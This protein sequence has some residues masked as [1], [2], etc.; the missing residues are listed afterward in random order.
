VDQTDAELVRRANAGSGRSFDVLVDRHYRRCLRYARHQ[1]GDATD[2]EDAVQEAF[3]RAWR[4][5]STCT[6][7]KFRPWLTTIVVNCCRSAGMRRKRKQAELPLDGLDGPDA[8]RLAVAPATPIRPIEETPVGRALAGLT[9]RLREAF[10]LRHVEE[11]TF[12][13]MARATG[14]GESAL[15]MRVRRAEQALATALERTHGE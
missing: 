1:L 13:E 14:A 7:E 4:S 6:P 8:V 9:P 2:A 12:A 5:L 10:L 11:L 15:K 3:V